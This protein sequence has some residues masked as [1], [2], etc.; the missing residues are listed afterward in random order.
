MSFFMQ[1]GMGY[2]SAELA[3]AAIGVQDAFNMYV[4]IGEGAYVSLEIDRITALYNKD[5]EPFLLVE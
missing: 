3:H 2:G 5:N 1:I 4:P